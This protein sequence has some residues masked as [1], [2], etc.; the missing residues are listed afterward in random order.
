MSVFD[1]VQ[2]LPLCK[3]I[4]KYVLNDFIFRPGKE[5]K[6]NFDKVMDHLL[7]GY[8]METIHSP[9]SGR[10]RARLPQHHFHR[11]GRKYSVR[12]FVR[13][14]RLREAGV[15]ELDAQRNEVIGYRL[16]LKEIEDIARRRALDIK[17]KSCFERSDCFGLSW[18]ESPLCFKHVILQFERDQ[19]VKTER[20]DEAYLR[21]RERIEPKI[22][23]K[24]SLWRYNKP[25]IHHS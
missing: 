1:E 22:K 9:S 11:L 14:Q 8:E 18:K 15:F 13:K 17:E 21:S 6:A 19:G 12:R 16:F 4:I 3:D 7:K 24:I 2:K 20:L 23:N 5:T 10:I 25:Q